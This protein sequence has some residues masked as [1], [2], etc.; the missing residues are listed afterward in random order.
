MTSTT[1]AKVPSDQGR[2][3]NSSMGAVAA[4]SIAIAAGFVMMMSF[5][6]VQESAKAELGLTDA[7]LAFIQGVSAAVPLVLFSIPIGIL[8]DRTNR[9]RLFILLGLVWTLGTAMTAF[10]W[11]VPTLFIARMLA[12]I[13]TTG[14]LTAALSLS[15]DLCRPAE[16]GRAILLITLGKTV[17]QGAAFAAVGWM[18]GYYAHHATGGMFGIKEPWRATHVAL[19]CASLAMLLPLLWVREPA[20]QEVEASTH[21]RFGVVCREL[22][23]RWHFLVPLFLGQ[24]T[25]VMADAAAAIW[26]APVLTRN[27]HLQ[28]DQFGGWMGAVM[29]GTGL[30]GAILGGIAADIGQKSGKRGGLLVGAVLAAVVGIPAAL[31]PLAGSTLM[32]GIGLGVL[33]LCGTITGLVTSV[34]LTVFLP[35][36]V[37]G[38]AIGAFIALAGL[39]GFGL[40]PSLVTMVS[41]MMGGEQ[42]L[43]SGLAIVGVVVSII[44]L[45]AFT[46]AMRNAP[47]A[48]AITASHEPI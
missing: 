7:N 31:F 29:F 30:V 15:A 4:I 22:M 17:G 8:V 32:F 48:A 26:A 40:A 41:T 33:V 18:F 3:L 13:G 19:A 24:V 9:M 28:P 20:R 35:N 23:S 6:T 1:L 36:E 21:P 27:F 45:I 47:E 2:S 14:A 46:F 39:I 12:G 10:A 42:H 34:A 44:S 43:A 38:L 37:R 25:V 16:R 5:G 11:D